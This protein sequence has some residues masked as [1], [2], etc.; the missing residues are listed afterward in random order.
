MENANPL[1]I[2]ILQDIDNTF[3]KKPNL[4]KVFPSSL[5]Q[6]I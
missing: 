6:K 5:V 2:F 3:K 4:D 1:S